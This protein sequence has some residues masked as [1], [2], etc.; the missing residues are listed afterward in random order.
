MYRALL[1][2]KANTG[3]SLLFINLAQAFGCQR[4]TILSSSIHGSSKKAIFSPSLARRHFVSSE[5]YHTKTLLET[6]VTFFSE[7]KQPKRLLLIDSP[8]LCNGVHPNPYTRK[9]MLLTL[10][11]LKEA[12]LLIHVVD[13]SAR[14]KPFFWEGVDERLSLYGRFGIRYVIAANK[15]DLVAGKEVLSRLSFLERQGQVVFLSAL[16]KEGLKY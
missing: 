1:V 5:P 2:G 11:A 13:V 8:S 9:I 7:G 14:G 15:I 10:Q 12:D 4:L 16:K 6:R 3:K